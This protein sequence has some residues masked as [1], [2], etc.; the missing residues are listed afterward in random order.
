ML[1]YCNGKM[2]PYLAIYC[3]TDTEW[4]DKQRLLIYKQ[5]MRP[6]VLIGYGSAFPFTTF[7]K[8]SYIY[9]SEISTSSIKVQTTPK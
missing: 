4:L 2:F 8:P 9:F 6:L 1:F 5:R 7:S 3:K